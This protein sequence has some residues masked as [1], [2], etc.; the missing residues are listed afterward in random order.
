MNNIYIIRS[1]FLDQTSGGHF[2]TN[3]SS[4]FSKISYHALFA[5][6][7]TYY[8]HHSAKGLII[9]DFEKTNFLKNILH[10]AHVRYKCDISQNYNSNSSINF[11]TVFRDRLHDR[12]KFWEKSINF[13][14]HK[15]F[16]HFMRT[17]PP[18][19]VKYRIFMLHKFCEILKHSQDHRTRSLKFWRYFTEFSWRTSNWNSITF[20]YGGGTMRVIFYKRKN[21]QKK[22]FSVNY[23]FH[24]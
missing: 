7:K 20:L 13:L 18:V 17:V 16:F 8:H 22:L 19:H 9:T 5:M 23:C 10:G 21:F 11:A 24:T 2:L 15:I 4:K 12:L 14:L 3:K 6:I 1:N